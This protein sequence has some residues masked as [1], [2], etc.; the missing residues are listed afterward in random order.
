MSAPP[1]E[2]V[3]LNVG[4]SL[5]QMNRQTIAASP[6]GLLQRMFGDEWSSAVRDAAGNVFICRDGAPFKA[7]VTY[8]RTGQALV[9]HGVDL[10]QVNVELDYF[11]DDPPLARTSMHMRHEAH[12]ACR[13]LRRIIPRIRQPMFQYVGIC[14]KYL[15]S[16]MH[17]HENDRYPPLVDALDEEIQSILHNVCNLKLYGS[18]VNSEGTLTV[19]FSSYDDCMPDNWGVIEYVATIVKHEQKILAKMFADKDVSVTF[20]QDCHSKKHRII[21]KLKFSGPSWLIK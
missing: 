17:V 19:E 3:I 21:V 13:A 16:G 8:I 5:Y 10:N 15:A 9:P 18:D 12:P 20:V 11:F 6:P 2:V 4:G 14:K 7:I 1:N